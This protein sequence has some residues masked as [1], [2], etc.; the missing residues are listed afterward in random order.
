[1]CLA[2]ESRNQFDLSLPRNHEILGEFLG[3]LRHQRSTFPLTFVPY[4]AAA[5]PPLPL[6]VLERWSGRTGEKSAEFLHHLQVNKRYRFIYRT[7]TFA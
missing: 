7:N 1:M 4:S 3:P 6:P 2:S 5:M